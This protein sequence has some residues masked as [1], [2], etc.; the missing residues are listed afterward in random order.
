MASKRPTH[1]ESEKQHTTSA[2][3]GQ[4]GRYRQGSQEG[5]STACHGDPHCRALRPG[6]PHPAAR[7]LLNLITR[8]PSTHQAAASQ[9]FPLQ[10]ERT[11]APGPTLNILSSCV[12][13][14]WQILYSIPWY[15]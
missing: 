13:Y 3:R 1:V 2:T 15:V 11:L 6:L 9:T 7:P 4:V 8:G 10:N 5:P 12:F 14:L